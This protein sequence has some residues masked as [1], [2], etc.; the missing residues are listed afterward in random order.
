[1]PGHKLRLHV[2][3]RAS[4]SE[5]KGRHGEA[6]KVRVTAPPVDG[7]A[8]KAVIELLADTLGVPRSAITLHSGQGGRRK[9]IQLPEGVEVPPEWRFAL[10]SYPSNTG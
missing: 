7:R 10:D 1:M 9:V 2:Q 5:I 8:N 6:L 3:P 4:R